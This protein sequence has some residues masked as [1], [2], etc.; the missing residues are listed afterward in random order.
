MEMGKAMSVG[1][2]GRGGG[3]AG[4]GEERRSGR[5]GRGRRGEGESEGRQPKSEENGGVVCGRE[6]IGAKI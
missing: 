6:A 1:E 3:V 2:G 5:E 4:L